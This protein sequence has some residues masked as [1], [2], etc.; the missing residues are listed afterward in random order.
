MKRSFLLPG[1]LLCTLFVSAQQSLNARLQQIAAT[2]KGKVGVSALL[3]ETGQTAE[4][5]A[6]QHYPMQ[7]VYKFPI[8]LAILQQVDKGKLQLNQPVQ[9]AKAE[10]IPTGHS[11]IRDNHP[12]GVTMPLR[13]VLRYN[14]TESDGTACDVLLRLLGGTKATQ[15]AIEALGIKDIAIATTEMVQVS[16][17]LVQYRNWST[18]IAMTRLL[19]IFYTK[20]VLSPAS[21][22]L[23]LKDM[24]ETPVGPQ[25]L[26]GLLPKGITVAH[27]TGTSGTVDGLTRATNDAGII[28]LPDGRHLIITVYVSDAHGTTAEKEGIIAKMAKACYDEWVK[29]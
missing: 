3:L 5:N 26:K 18:P 12:D 19:R 10:L 7:S 22:A 15:K 17:E 27:K 9:I 13:E 20:E 11:P 24:T 23:L 6:Q 29:G 2:I 14:V 4:L 8:A 1:L 25:R 28:T 16:D 21:K